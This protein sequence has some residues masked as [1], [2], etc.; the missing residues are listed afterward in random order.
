MTERGYGG[1]SRDREGARRRLKGRRHGDRVAG[2]RLPGG[3][4]K[5]SRRAVGGGG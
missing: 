2:G 3:Q 4:K 5:R 1:C